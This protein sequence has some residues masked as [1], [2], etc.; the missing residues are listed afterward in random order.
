MGEDGNI[1][2]IVSSNCRIST[3]LKSHKGYRNHW[4]IMSD[5]RQLTYSVGTAA[6]TR[7]VN[8]T[9]VCTY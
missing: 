8:A 6:I 4:N 7:L 5:I 2:W 1:N 9:E 3:S